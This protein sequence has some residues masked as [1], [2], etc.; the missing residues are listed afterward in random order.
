MSDKRI[1]HVFRR[2]RRLP[3]LTKG[4]RRT[5]PRDFIEWRTLRGWGQIP[6]WELEPAGYLLRLAREEA[7]LTQRALAERMGITQQAIAQAERWDANPTV[8]LLRRWAQA[9]DMEL[10]IVFRR[11]RTSREE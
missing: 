4:L 5:R 11:E 3:P 10:E 9:C 2:R 6:P 7:G 1:F 8:A